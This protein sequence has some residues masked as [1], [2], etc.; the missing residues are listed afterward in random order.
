[1]TDRIFRCAMLLS[2][3]FGLLLI[4]TR[5][6]AEP[7]PDEKDR[8]TAQ[9]VC[10]YLQRGHLNKP[11]IGYDISRRLFRR[12]IKDLDP[13]KLYFTKADIDDLKKQETDLDDMVLKGDLSFAFKV[14]GKFVARVAQRVKLVEELVDL[15]H[16]F[17]AKESMSTVRVLSISTGS[18]ATRRSNLRRRRCGGLPA[19]PRARSRPPFPSPS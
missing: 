15:K 3:A 18:A 11:E 14:Y 10:E 5:L 12:F 13:A 16:D 4:P 1:M 17:T 8:M 7:K 19:W 9:L 6:P 2:I